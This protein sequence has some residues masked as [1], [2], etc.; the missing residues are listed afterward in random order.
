VPKLSKADKRHKISSAEARRRKE[1][2]LARIREMEADR[3]AG[4]LIDR[5][6]VES[7]WFAKARQLRDGILMIPDR[8]SGLLLNQS[9]QPKIH[10]ILTKELTKALSDL[11]DDI[12]RKSNEKDTKAHARRKSQGRTFLR[13]KQ[14]APPSRL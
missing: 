11:A 5:S 8:I 13:P 7:T 3:L 12:T 1:V 14:A 6:T 10:A 4:K 2:A 9:E